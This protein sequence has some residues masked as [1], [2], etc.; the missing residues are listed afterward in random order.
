MY[1]DDDEE[2]FLGSD[3]EDDDFPAFEHLPHLPPQLMPGGPWRRERSYI[4]NRPGGPQRI[5]TEEPAHSL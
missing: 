2:E 5:V 3:D 4:P 1:S